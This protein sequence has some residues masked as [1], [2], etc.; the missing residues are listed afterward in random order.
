MVNL[1]LSPVVT[2]NVAVSSG[3]TLRN[4]YALG[5]IVGNSAVISTSERVRK[6]NSLQEVAA[7][8]FNATSSEYKAAAVYFAQNP[9]PAAVVIGVKGGAETAVE[10]VTACREANADWYGFTYIPSG[11]ASD[12]DIAALAAYAEAAGDCLYFAKSSTATILTGGAPLSTLAT[13]AYKRTVFFYSADTLADAGAAA[14][15][16]AMGLNNATTAG[17]SFTLAYKPLVGIVPD[18]LTEAQATTVKN[19]N[20]NVYI[21]RGG[22]YNLIEAGT[23]MDGTYADEV[24]GLDNYINALQSGVMDLFTSNAKIPNTEAGLTQIINAL[25][26]ESDAFVRSGFISA[27]IWQA[28]PV[29]DL[30]T[31]DALTAGYLFQ[32]QPLAEQT[33]AERA[34]RRATIY[35]A[36]KLAGAIQ[37]VTIQLN[38][39][40]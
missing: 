11:G 17:G 35:G 21:K 5:L 8:G 38:V 39:N 20:G 30:Q 31:G 27:G 16:A 37:Y 6:Y 10:A 15:G 14:M 34:M 33:P 24:I 28:A 3:A 18:D 7:D 32:A 2:V 4:N 36:V 19:L 40:R 12:S 22:R 1:P 13:A 23:C 29:L 25:N 9:A 26:A